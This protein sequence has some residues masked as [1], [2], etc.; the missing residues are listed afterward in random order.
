MTVV[1]ATNDPTNPGTECMLDAEYITGVN[2][3]TNTVITVTPG[4]H[5]KQE[6]FLVWLLAIQAQGP[7]GAKVHR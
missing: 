5:D 2:Q 3:G 4:L 7:N 1:G 6:P